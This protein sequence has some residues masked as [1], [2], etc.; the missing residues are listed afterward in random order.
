MLV[1]RAEPEGSKLPGNGCKPQ[2]EVLS[3]IQLGLVLSSFVFWL[4]HGFPVSNSIKAIHFVLTKYHS[5][6]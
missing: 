1:G 2:S 4:L 5:G 3:T 6:F